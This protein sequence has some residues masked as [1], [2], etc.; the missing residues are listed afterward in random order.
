[1][2]NFT[3]KHLWYQS[4]LRPTLLEGQDRTKGAVWYQPIVLETN[5]TRKHVWYQS[6]LRLTLLE[7][8][9]GTNRS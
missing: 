5:F 7:S 3:R 8:M 2:T 9:F 1:M 6:F 4:F